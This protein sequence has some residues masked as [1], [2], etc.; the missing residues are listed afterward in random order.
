MSA[1]QPSRGSLGI[2]PTKS[3][4]A[5]GT[6]AMRVLL[7]GCVWWLLD[8]GRP[9]GAAIGVVA[10]AL[11]LVAGRLL[12]GEPPG[13]WRLRGVI[14][15][16]SVFVVGSVRGGIDVARRAFARNPTLS[17]Y[18]L[19]EQI[20]VPPGPARELFKGAMTMMPGSFCVTDDADTIELHVLARDSGTE[21]LSER[22][23]R[24][25][26]RARGVEVPRA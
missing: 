2:L 25:T 12:G 7:L 26:T 19:R 15:L 16:A 5:W 24:A 6:L 17:P 23:Q 21:R 3:I 11:V 10:V 4:R 8:E 1:Q 9:G 20:P 18:M 14:E 13:R 22:L